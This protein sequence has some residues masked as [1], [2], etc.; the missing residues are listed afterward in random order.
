MRVYGMTR[1]TEDRAT[2]LVER[3]VDPVPVLERARARVVVVDRELH[4]TRYIARGAHIHGARTSKY[5][6]A[7]A[8]LFAAVATS[9]RSWPKRETR[10]SAGAATAASA[11]RTGPSM[12]AE[13]GYTWIQSRR[14]KE[15]GLS[16]RSAR[17]G[18]QKE[19]SRGRRAGRWAGIAPSQRRAALVRVRRCA[20][21]RVSRRDHR[22]ALPALPSSQAMQ[23]SLLVHKKSRARARSRYTT[24]GNGS[25]QAWT[26]PVREFKSRQPDKDATLLVFPCSHW[27]S[28]SFCILTGPWLPSDDVKVRSREYCYITRPDYGASGVRHGPGLVCSMSMTS[29]P[30]SRSTALT[31]T[32]MYVP[33]EAKRRPRVRGRAF[34]AAGRLE[35]KTS[36]WS[37]DSTRQSL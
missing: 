20:E 18:Q 5:C 15:R 31:R 10:A 14:T 13:E 24:L 6:A 25:T 3:A 11:R 8:L 22:Y 4:T 19:A 1:R 30:Q 35:V 21:D 32:H 16:S 28:Q 9:T 7:S 17:R 34:S 2:G 29:L 37:L 36:L 23:S 33:T 12:P 27:L 26:S